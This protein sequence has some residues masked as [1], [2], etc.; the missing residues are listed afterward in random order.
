MKVRV[1]CSIKGIEQQAWDGLCSDTVFSHGWLKAIEENLPPVVEPRHLLLE[2]A[3]R[4]LGILPC[5]IQRG[6]PYYDLDD[7]LFGPL[8]GTFRR[9]G[10]SAL[11]ALLAY[12]P[13]AHRTEL[14]LVDG[15]DRSGAIR[16][17][18]RA[19]NRICRDE[20]LRTSGWLFVEGNDSGRDAALRDAGLRPAFLAP[21]AI[22]EN[23]FED[24]ESYRR[25]LGRSPRRSVR[26][27]L[28]RSAR[29]RLRVRSESC[30]DVDDGTL[31]RLNS[32]H[33]QRYQRDRPSPLGP[34]FFEALKHTLGERVF[35]HTV[36]DGDELVSYSLV[37]G[38]RRRW[39]MFVGGHVAD[40][41]SHENTIFF[42]LNYYHPIR[43]AIE[44]GVER[45]DFGLSSYEAKVLRGCR[46][47][48]VSLWLSAHSLPWRLFLPAWLRVV[49][50]RYRRK[51][52]D[53]RV[54]SSAAT[55]G[56]PD[57]EPGESEGLQQL[58][59]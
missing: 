5:W 2:E 28:N 17:F 52:G 33:Y 42:N 12:S 36:R 23:R 18:V 26:N 1:L 15:V 7:R 38:D 13:L 8:A 50:W 47:E 37:V 48:S 27:E 22:W 24:F 44:S 32:V 54:E 25:N 10:L 45:I 30:D 14:F 20:N 21:T 41:R 55:E 43:A 58:G 16:H 53:L 9:L 59:V 6:D 11:P 40:E 49:D 56:R 29:S 57:S 51:H 34:R 39:H 19:M 4:L 35:L 31:A 46:L 3:G